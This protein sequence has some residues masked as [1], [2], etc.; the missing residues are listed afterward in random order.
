MYVLILKI[1]CKFVEVLFILRFNFYKIDINVMNYFYINLMVE[2][3]VL[4]K[5]MILYECNVIYLNFYVI[6]V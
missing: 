1:C 6:Y 5:L 3:F 2:G 4:N